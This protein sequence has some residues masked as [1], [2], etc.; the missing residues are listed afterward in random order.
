MEK[1]ETFIPLQLNKEKK[2]IGYITTRMNFKI[3]SNEDVLLID[4]MLITTIPKR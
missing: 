3:H 4:C 2:S 1:G